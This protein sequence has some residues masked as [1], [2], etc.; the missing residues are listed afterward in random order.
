M[1]DRRLVLLEASHL[2]AWQ[3]RFGHLHREGEFL[4]DEHGLDAFGEYL[5]RHGAS[6]FHLLADV[7]EEGFQIGDVPHV[8]GRDR[9][10]L[11]ARKLGQYFHGTHLSAAFPLGR[12]KSGRRDEKWLFS[13]LTQPRLFSPWLEVMRRTGPRLAGIFSMPQMV[14]I[15]SVSFVTRKAV[16]YR[17]F[18]FISLTHG[19]L[20]QTFIE[21]GH[22]HFSR[23]TPLSIHAIDEAAT[24]S[25]VEAEKIHH[26]L[27]GQR[28]IARGTRLPILLFI[29]PDHMETFK[30]RCR[31]TSELH[32]E[33][34][35]LVAEAT[36]GGLGTPPRNS[37]CEELFLHLLIRQTPCRQFAPPEE[38]RHYQLW[39]IHFGMT[40]ISLG[41]LVSALLFAVWQG[42]ETDTL[43]RETERVRGEVADGQRRHDAIR[44]ALP[45]VSL[46][47]ENLRVLISRHEALLKRGV[48]PEPMYIDLGRALRDSPRIELTRLDWRLANRSGET[49]A[50]GGD[51]A[52]PFGILEIFGQLPIDLAY[53][54]RVHRDTIDAFVDQLRTGPDIHEVRVLSRPL[55]VESDKLL[56]SPVDVARQ[57]EAPKFSLRIVRRL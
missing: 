47:T 42:Y 45:D 20:R 38:C 54:H 37:Y 19:G 17:N 22:L 5:R 36:H 21:D 13:A 24:A 23:L 10:D 52:G 6:V 3:W 29:H 48:G 50:S 7:A 55:E 28:Q 4:A 8:T 51:I 44:K 2:T 33:F 57:A 1:P 18:L 46:S 35:D 56:R 11:I 12:E 25:I 32:F 49:S 31:D 40:C 16:G 43:L 41:A 14:E 39:R 15:L 53:D 26:Y 34:V 9:V 27:S 30:N